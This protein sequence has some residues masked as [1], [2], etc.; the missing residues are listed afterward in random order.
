MFEEDY[1]PVG[2]SG[3]MVRSD[4]SGWGW[5][6]LILGVVV[7]CAGV[8]LTRG[9][10]WARIVAV[11]VAVLSAIINLAFMSAYPIWSVI[12]ITIDILMIY[13]VTVHGDRDSLEG[14]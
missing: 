2:D 3:L 10:T 5:M 11:M 14:Y 12:M 13:A 8:A 1:Y 7:A 6:H 4:Y 9:E